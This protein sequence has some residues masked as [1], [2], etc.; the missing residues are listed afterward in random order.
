M[1]SKYVIMAIALMIAATNVFGGENKRGEAG[2][3]FLKVPLGARETA[4]GMSGLTTSSGAG[5]IYWNPANIAASDRPRS[6]SR[7]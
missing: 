6:I 5:A 3:M 2:F 1:K 7:M 4:M